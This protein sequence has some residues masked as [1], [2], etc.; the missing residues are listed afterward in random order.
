MASVKHGDVQPQ[1]WKFFSGE[2]ESRFK[3]KLLY[4]RMRTF[5][6]SAEEAHL[7]HPTVK[8]VINHKNVVRRGLGKFT[9]VKETEENIIYAAVHT[10][11]VEG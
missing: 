10:G 6:N 4:S 2:T 5:R 11:P 8:L 1:S 9:L 3:E 7:S